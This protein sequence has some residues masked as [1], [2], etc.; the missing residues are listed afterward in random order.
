MLNNMTIK[1]R[2]VIM[3]GF[4]SV[5]LAG[6]GVLGI[7]GLSQS[8]DA[9][10]G[11]IPLG[12]L[13]LIVDRMQRARL[14]AVV[15][16]YGRNGEV[17]KQRQALNEQRDAEIAATWQQYLTNTLTVE[18]KKLAD[19]FG[20]Q[21][22]AYI[23]E[24]NRTM[25]LAAA[26]EFDEAIKNA[27]GVATPKF[28][29]AHGTLFK[30][31]EMR[32]NS[33]NKEYAHAESQYQDTLNITIAAVAVGVLLAVLIGYLLVRAILGP[34]N[35]AIEAANR[36]A[37]GDLTGHI[38]VNSTNEMGKLLQALKTMNDNLLDLV[39]KVRNSTESI[40]TASGEI[41]SGN[42]DLS[43]RTEEQASSLEETASSMEELT[44]TVRQ[45]ADNARQANQLAVGAAEVA[46]KGGAV[47]GQ[48]VQTMSSIH[49]SSKKVVE[50]ISVID[51]I[52][53]QTNILALNAAVEAA[54]AGE[55]GRGF[56]VVA[57]EVR[58]LAQRSAAAAK[59]IKE[60]IG[61]SVAK[62]G[63]GTKLVDEAGL[64]MDE[65][66]TAVKRVTDI[67][68]EISAASQE[69]SSGIDQ[70]SQAVTQMDE[71]TQQN[72]ALVEEA[73]AAAESMKEQSRVLTQAVSMFKFTGRTERAASEPA[74]KKLPAAT[75]TKLPNRRSAIKQAIAATK[76]DAAA[77]K[78]APIPRKAAAGGSDWEEF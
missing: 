34:L 75:L 1:S 15:S 24:R 26:G 29:A 36:V 52:A 13:G 51:G 61:D 23:E 25:T 50:I 38:E 70:I 57:T 77:E 28:D 59:E 6:M 65:I 39:G 18:E 30:L 17:V 32:R 37:S 20:Q 16:A 54:R 46:K 9:F 71:A 47:V 44:S 19:D 35:K 67:M 10:K 7:S 73:S 49:D 11:A 64:T 66:V 48:V 58:T 63:E 21:W 43:Q 12:D 55:Q 76:V 8:N 62:V 5:L 60:L 45:N 14:N 69:Q 22:K 78:S 42:S 53:F 4:F 68:S 31:L 33:A 74:T 72:A 3:I 56:A 27:T 2:L 41:A 40:A